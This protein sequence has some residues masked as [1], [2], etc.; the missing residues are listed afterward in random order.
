MMGAY[1]KSVAASLLAVIVCVSVFAPGCPKELR[2]PVCRVGFWAL[3]AVVGTGVR[4]RPYLFLALFIFY[5]AVG[6]LSCYLLLRNFLG[7]GSYG[8]TAVVAIIPPFAFRMW[9]DQIFE[10]VFFSAILYAAL[11]TAAAWATQIV[12]AAL[13]KQK[14]Q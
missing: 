4:A 11:G 10:P 5:V 12:G 9:P 14:S 1:L 3:S 2:I 8:E 6:A 7:W 13:G